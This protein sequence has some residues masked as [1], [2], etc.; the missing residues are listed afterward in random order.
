MIDF[1]AELLGQIGDE[2]RVAIGRA[3]GVLGRDGR[4]IQ[5]GILALPFLRGGGNGGEGGKGGAK[6]KTA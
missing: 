6:H 4:K 2:G 3:G 5:L 1:N